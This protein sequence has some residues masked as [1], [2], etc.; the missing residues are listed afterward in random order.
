M[1]TRGICSWQKCQ[2]LIFRSDVPN[3]ASAI[4]KYSEHYF[5]FF[6]GGGGRNAR[7]R[8]G[9]MATDAAARTGVLSPAVWDVC[10]ASYE[11]SWHESGRYL[12]HVLPELLSRHWSSAPLDRQWFLYWRIQ[13]MDHVAN[14]IITSTDQRQLTRSLIT[15]YIWRLVGLFL[16]D[17]CRCRALF[18]HLIT[19][20][21]THI[22]THSVGFLWTTDQHVLKAANYTTYIK[23]KGR[24]SMPSAGFEPAIAATGRPQSYNLDLTATC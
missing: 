22:H 17:H 14:R 1:S 9:C 23:Q 3:S 20:N 2:M 8:D 6:E 13:I 12:A 24:T 16:P 15:K 10:A 21:Y 19:H 4:P 7:L 5:F 18:M 11:W